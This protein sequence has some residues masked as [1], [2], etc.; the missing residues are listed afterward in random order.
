MVIKVKQKDGTELPQGLSMAFIG[1]PRAFTRFLA[2]DDAAQSRVVSAA[3]GIT[4]RGDMEALVSSI[5]NGDEV[6]QSESYTTWK[7]PPVQS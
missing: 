3:R 2:L 1:N 7:N 4:Q 6:F 5:G